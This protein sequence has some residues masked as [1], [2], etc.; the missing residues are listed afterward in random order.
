[1][2][3]WQRL[4]CDGIGPSLMPDTGCVVWFV[5]SARLTNR[6]ARK[7]G[8]KEFTPSLPGSALRGRL[9]PHRCGETRAS[10]WTN[11]LRFDRNKNGKI[12]LRSF[13]HKPYEEGP[14]RL[15]AGNSSGGSREKA[16]FSCSEPQPEADE[17]L[18]QK[19]HAPQ[20]HFLPSLRSPSVEWVKCGVVRTHGR[21]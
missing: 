18:A 3:N 14:A 10:T 16:S 5:P 2:W 7:R 1:M 4:E 20:A 8:L 11:G 15:D 21:D 9:V 17:P 12:P 6:Q 13:R 19:A